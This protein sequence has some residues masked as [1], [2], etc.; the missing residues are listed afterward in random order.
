MS[1]R[2]KQAGN[3][4]VVPVVARIAR[5]IND[6]LLKPSSTRNEIHI[7]TA[8]VDQLAQLADVGRTLAERIVADRKANGP[9]GDPM[10]LTRVK[11]IGEGIVSNNRS[12]IDV[13]SAP[14][15][16]EAKDRATSKKKRKTH[17]AKTQNRKEKPS[18]AGTKPVKIRP[19]KTSSKEKPSVKGTKSMQVKSKG[20]VKRSP[21]KAK[22]LDSSRK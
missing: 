7:N 3:S 8:S 13:G 22:K 21:I 15:K 11:G 19:S 16:R 2:F 14:S 4:V 5:E 12:V 6:C 20:K 9:Y 18:V 17:P 1:H 10:Q